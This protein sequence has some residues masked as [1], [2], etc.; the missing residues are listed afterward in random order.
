MIFEVSK[1]SAAI[2]QLDWA[3]KLF[4]DHQAYIPAITLAGAAEEILSKPICDQAALQLLK[5][6]LSKDYLLEEKDVADNHLNKSK[7]WLKH[8][9]ASKIDEKIEAELDEDAIQMITRA[10]INLVTYDGSFPSEGVR[11][12]EWTQLNRQDVAGETHHI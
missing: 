11:F 7:N 9:S 2:D 3:I 8:G 4:L 10:L 12:L 6:K 1:V 5:K